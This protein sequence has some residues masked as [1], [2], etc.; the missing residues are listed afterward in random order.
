MR[1]G[2][3]WRRTMRA[4]WLAAALCAALAAVPAGV[5]LGAGGAG[6]FVTVVTENPDNLNPYLHGLLA[7]GSVYRYVFDSPF[8]V[9]WRGNWK[10]ALATAYTVS[11][12]GKTWTL[13]LRPGVRWSDGRPF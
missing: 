5:A 12:D 9:D 3:H 7:S 6:T 8:T 10:P 4:S 13:T 11:P 1:A 2:R